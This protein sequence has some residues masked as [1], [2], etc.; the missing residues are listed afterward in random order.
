M[1]GN[2]FTPSDWN[3]GIVKNDFTPE[4]IAWFREMFSVGRRMMPFY[5]GDFYPLT[6]NRAT[7][8]LDGA[9]RS[10]NLDEVRW[11]AWQM[12]RADQEAGFAIF[13]RR[14]NTPDHVFTASLG[15]IDES[16]SYEVETWRGET[17][18]MDGKALK[19]L[20]VELRQPR[21][22]RLVFYRKR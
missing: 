14:L 3:A 5:E 6:D 18:R 20:K 7:V 12:H 16:A 2:V 21:S 22:F 4:Q 8:S 13:F 1:S 15:G 10:K 11:C 19:S 17:V 9:W